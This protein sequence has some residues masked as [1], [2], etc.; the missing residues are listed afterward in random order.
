[1][2]GTLAVHDIEISGLTGTPDQFVRV[3]SKMATQL[4]AREGVWVS[5][6]VTPVCGLTTLKVKPEIAVAPGATCPA[7]DT[8]VLVVALPPHT[9]S[10]LAARQVLG[11]PLYNKGCACAIGVVTDT[12]LTVAGAFKLHDHEAGQKGLPVSF[13]FPVLLTTQLVVDVPTVQFIVIS[14]ATEASV[15]TSFVTEKMAF[16]LFAKLGA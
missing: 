3:T 13:G 16:Q 5:A 14:G 1:M 2:V 6:I 4:L 8:E 10:L 11:A 12:P 7:M 15:Q 9:L